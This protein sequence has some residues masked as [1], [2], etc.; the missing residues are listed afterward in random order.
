MHKPIVPVRL[1]AVFSAYPVNV[2]HS[3]T[4]FSLQLWGST[5]ASLCYYVT[6]KL[7]CLSVSSSKGVVFP[8]ESIA[9]C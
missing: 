3:E 9:P 7:I 4:G 1:S 5:K 2:I 6:D 8:S